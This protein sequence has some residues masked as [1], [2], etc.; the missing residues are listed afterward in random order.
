MW[1]S[2]PTQMHSYC[3]SRVSNT[4][5]TTTSS[6]SSIAIESTTIYINFI[7]IYCVLNKLQEKSANYKKK[8]IQIT[9]IIRNLYIYIWKYI[10]Y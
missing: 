7:I 4:S 3:K 10:I 6:T 9:K 1:S 5:T 2:H 8:D